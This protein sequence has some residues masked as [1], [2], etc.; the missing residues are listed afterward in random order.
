VLLLPD[1]P[2]QHILEYLFNARNYHLT[3]PHVGYHFLEGA[4]GYDGPSCDRYRLYRHDRTFML[5]HP[6]DFGQYLVVCPKDMQSSYRFASW[7]HRRHEQ[8]Q[9]AGG[10]WAR[11]CAQSGEL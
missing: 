10:G 6:S 7:V 9:A 4:K 1:Q 11:R 8:L 2:L 5:G 3:R